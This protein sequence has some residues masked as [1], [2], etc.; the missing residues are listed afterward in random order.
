MDAPM[1]DWKE[2]HLE[3][4]WGDWLATLTGAQME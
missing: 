3:S 1:G 4:N 2:G